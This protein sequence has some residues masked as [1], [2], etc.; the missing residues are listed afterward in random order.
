MNALPLFLSASLSLPS[1][2]IL[3]ILSFSSVD[4]VGSLPGSANGV[5]D[6]VS[7]RYIPP[8]AIIF[9]FCYPLQECHFSWF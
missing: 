9:R 1:L 6:A 5:D 4:S 8:Q 7:V 3:V 2:G